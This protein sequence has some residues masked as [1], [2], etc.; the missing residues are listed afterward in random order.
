MGAYEADIIRGILA[1]HKAPD[2][3]KIENQKLVE[4]VNE[5]LATQMRLEGKRCE[6]CRFFQNDSE[7]HK[8]PPIAI[9]DDGDLIGAWPPVGEE[10]WCGSFE[11][12][13]QTASSIMLDYLDE[14]KK[15]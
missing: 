13:R 2:T 11:Q 12:D 3:S 14:A 4:L 6:T 8:H 15:M 9:V 5:C 1:G 10:D 7:C